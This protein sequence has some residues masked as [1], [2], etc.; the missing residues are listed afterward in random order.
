MHSEQYIV[1]DG[2]DGKPIPNID[3][4]SILWLE[5]LLPPIISYIGLLKDIELR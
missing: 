4:L 5:R 1:S 2:Q 3:L